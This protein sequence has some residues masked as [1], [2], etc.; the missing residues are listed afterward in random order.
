[1]ELKELMSLVDQ[2]NLTEMDRL[3]LD[4][5]SKAKKVIED[6]LRA[7]IMKEFDYLGLTALSGVCGRT[8]HLK[9]SIEPVV[10]EWP[11]LHKYIITTGHLDLLHKRLTASAVK[12]RWADGID[13]PGVD[14]Y[15]ERKLILS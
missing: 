8:A 1:M 12:L 6:D 14:R 10:N 2:L 11:S 4:R 7:R 9:T 5:L 13:I 15:E 3:E